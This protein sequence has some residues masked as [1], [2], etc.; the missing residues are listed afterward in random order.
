MRLVRRAVAPHPF[1]EQRSAVRKASAS[2][3]NRISVGLTTW[4]GTG[5]PLKC[6]VDRRTKLNPLS[7][8]VAGVVAGVVVGVAA[9]RIYMTD[10]VW[11]GVWVSG[12]PL[13]ANEGLWYN[14]KPGAD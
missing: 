8:T 4:V 6:T 5:L 1:G 3:V 11:R 12:R 9:A 2:S 13:D 7:V 14:K 10:K